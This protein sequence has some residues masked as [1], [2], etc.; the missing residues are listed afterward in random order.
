MGDS[1]RSAITGHINEVPLPSGQLEARQKKNSKDQILAYIDPTRF[2]YGDSNFYQFAILSDGYSGITAK[3]MDDFIAR[4]CAYQE[5]KY[6]TTSK[7][8]GMGSSFVT[9]AQTYGINEV[10]LLCHAAL[11]SAW[12]CST[13]A[14]GQSKRI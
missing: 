9:A 5:K 4:Q 2:S 13:L 12:G 3:Q 1:T 11:E 10:Y 14:Q 6:G 8:R 7:L